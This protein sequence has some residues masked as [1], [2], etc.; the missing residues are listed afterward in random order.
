MTPVPPPFSLQM[1]VL[2][3]HSNDDS[4]CLEAQLAASQIVVADGCWKM[5]RV[6]S[7]GHWWFLQD[8]DTLNTQMLDFLG[9]AAQPEAAHAG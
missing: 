5:L 2:G 7:G 9:S 1:P 4:F 8:P 3:V 6:A